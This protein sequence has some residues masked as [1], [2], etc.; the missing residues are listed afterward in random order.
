VFL[1][2]AL[3][4]VLLVAN[5]LVGGTLW[6]LHAF[7]LARATGSDLQARLA[8]VEALIA[9]PDFT[10]PAV[11]AQLLPQV[12]AAGADLRTLEAVVPFGMIGPQ[13]ATARALRL[14][15]AFADTAQATIEAIQ[16]VEPALGALRTSVLQGNEAPLAVGEHPLTLADIHAAQVALR[17]ALTAWQDVPNMSASLRVDALALIPSPALGRMMQQLNQLVPSISLGLATA[18][19]VLDASPALLGADQPG[20]TL[21]IEMNPDVLRPTGGIIE[22]YAL[23]AFDHG[24]LVSGVTLHRLTSEQCN[25]RICQSA[26][27][28]PPASWYPLAAAPVDL[29]DANLDPELPATGYTIQRDFQQQTGAQV[30][31]IIAITPAFYADV[32]SA[33]GAVQVP[34]LPDSFTSDNVEDRLRFYHLHPEALPTTV[35][36]NALGGGAVADP[37]ALVVEAIMKALSHLRA[38]RQSALG[39]AIVQALTTKDL[40]LYADDARVEAGL[41]GMGISG[42]VASPAGDSL[43]VV[44]TN[45]DDTPLNPY[46]RETFEDTITLDATG[47][48]HHALALTYAFAPSQAGA[49]IMQPGTRYADV[50]RVVLPNR[51]EAS[52][53]AG[54]CTPITITQEYHR[55]L[56][57]QFI[58]HPDSVAVIRASWYVPAAF[59]PLATSSA[60]GGTSTE[61]KLLVQRQPGARDDVMFTI[62]P[63]SG[64]RIASA[65][66][67]A[68]LVSGAATWRASPLVRDTTV[69]VTLF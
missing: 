38:N 30:D 53:I 5:I 47:G 26:A 52:M 12:Q 49:P 57:C 59:V 66:G 42:H 29:R 20:T 15:I 14:G 58:L 31:G 1:A 18:S 62:Q 13:A 67:P 32:L 11:L 51:A 41:T 36:P 35:H 54:A 46:V 44:D 21:L 55:V 10:Q 33:I 7:A 3:L 2:R 56:A 69:G 50:V 16:D 45:T 37:D 8:R 6:S 9:Q 64:T 43:Q 4:C 27:L 61:Y 24:R 39:R 60:D 48:A 65:I 23:V 22:G 40:Q 25:G 17:L 34:G 63:P 28:P 19:A 68:H